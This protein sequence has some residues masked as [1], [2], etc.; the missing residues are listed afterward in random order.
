MPESFQ[1]S[2]PAQAR[3]LQ[4]KQPAIRT[5]AAKVSAAR[6]PTSRSLCIFVPPLRC[7]R[8][9]L[10]PRPYGCYIF[11]LPVVTHPRTRSLLKSVP[12]HGTQNTEHR[13]LARNLSF[14]S[15]F[16]APCS[17]LHRVPQ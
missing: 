1:S 5:T 3:L 12:E 11:Q 13:P 6:R 4:P 14:L 8:L 2:A 16:R 15:V 17:V 9:P 10:A 7:D